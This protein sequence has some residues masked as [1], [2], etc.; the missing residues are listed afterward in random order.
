M[1]TIT[2]RPPRR[3][4]TRLHPTTA[5]RQ[6]RTMPAHAD[7]LVET[8]SGLLAV[9]RGV[10]TTGDPHELVGSHE[11]ARIIGHRRPTHL[12]HSLLA[13]ADEVTH[14]TD[15]TVRRRAW[16]RETLWRYTATARAD[17]TTII[18]GRLALDRTAIADRF[19]IHVSTVDAAIAAAPDNG[20]PPP[21]DG[22][23]RYA[24]DIDTWYAAQQQHQL[25]ALT[26]IDY[27]GD[28]DDLVTR[29]E[30]ARIAGYRD[31]RNLLNS[32]LAE[33]LLALNNPDHNMTMPHGRT[34]RTR[35]RWPR[36][37][38]WQAAEART[39]RRG[40]PA[41]TT[42]TIDRTGD[43]DDLVTAPEAARTLGYKRVSGLPKALL[44]AAD[45]QGPPRRWRRSTLW[46]FNDNPRQPST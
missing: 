27:T 37:V 25:D 21:V 2:T 4:R 20:F 12:P 5:V 19:G 23:W 30:A 16:K 31:H 11:A 22:R 1:T 18:D 42:R 3:R 38:V 46:H 32:P 14:N 35:H 6:Y 29:P 13:I 28:P 9:P 24:D 8:P 34:G 39:N 17:H 36:H 33:T 10:D 41:G 44:A 7:R 26:R 15:G 40:R 45:E 43:P